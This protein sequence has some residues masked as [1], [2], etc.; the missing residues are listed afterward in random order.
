MQI[1]LGTLQWH[2]VKR[3]NVL[4]PW[5][6]S[7]FLQIT[8][9]IHA[10]IE[11]HT[12]RQL[13]VMMI[14]AFPIARCK[15]KLQ[16]WEFWDDSPCECFTGNHEKWEARTSLASCG[17][18]KTINRFPRS[19]LCR[20]CIV[21]IQSSELWIHWLYKSVFRKGLQYIVNRTLKKESSVWTRC[22]GNRSYKKFRK[23]PIGVIF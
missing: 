14:T 7:F 20:Q 18:R 12:S 21:K 6:F 1:R 17:N 23:N 3:A 4:R 8:W 5:A 2:Q 19:S 15:K 13:F 22:L 16:N 9:A 11:W 10:W